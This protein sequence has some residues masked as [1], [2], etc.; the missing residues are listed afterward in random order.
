MDKLRQEEK[1]AYATSRAEHAK[2][3]EGVKL[4]MKLLRD[5]YASDASHDA[6]SGAAGGIIGLLETI[7]SDMTKT[8]AGLDSEE[9]SAVDEYGTLS[10]KN[11]IE[12]AAKEESV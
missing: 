10:K 5:Y 3:L 9:E 6:A 2:G 4:A 12:R 1:E 8:I 11:E 7:E